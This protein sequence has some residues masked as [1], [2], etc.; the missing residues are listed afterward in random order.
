MAFHIEDVWCCFKLLYMSV[1]HITLRWSVNV[2]PRYQ[3]EPW[4]REWRGSMM[5]SLPH[6]QNKIT[7]IAQ[8]MGPT[9]VLSAPDGPHDDPVNLVIG[10]YRH[11]SHLYPLVCAPWMASIFVNWVG[12]TQTNAK[13]TSKTALQKF[14]KTPPFLGLFNFRNKLTIPCKLLRY[15]GYETMIWDRNLFGGYL[16]DRVGGILMECLS[17]HTIGN[18]NN[19]S[20][21]FANYDFLWY[22]ILGFNIYICLNIFWDAKILLR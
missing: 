2:L 9:W 14:I 19:F 7:Q 3:I 22:A 18:H 16:T 21:S 20:N 1:V 10:V 5:M 15:D 4:Q 17:G 13:L 11:K 8:F 6:R 12:T